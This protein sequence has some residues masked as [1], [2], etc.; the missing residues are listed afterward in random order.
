M[1]F[2]PWLPPTQQIGQERKKDKIK[3]LKERKKNAEAS[4]TG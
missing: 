3:L 2:V 4:K 1:A